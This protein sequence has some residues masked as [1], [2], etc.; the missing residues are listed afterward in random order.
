MKLLEFGITLP[1]PAADLESVSVY[2]DSVRELIEGR[3]DWE[4]QDDIYLATFA[5]SKLAMWRDLDLIRNHGTDNPIVLALAG[6]ASEES[7]DIT[8]TA[9]IA[10]LQGDL[11]GGRMD[12]VLEVR[13]QFAV[14]LYSKVRRA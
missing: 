4:V 8:P 1:D 13:D 6:V 11:S 10:S 2:L 9:E 5:Y 3:P 14:L 12:D 7:L